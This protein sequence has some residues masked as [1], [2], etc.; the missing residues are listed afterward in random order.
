ME[1]CKLTFLEPWCT[2]SIVSTIIGDKI[3]ETLSSNGVTLKKTQSTHLPSIQ[4]LGVCCFLQLARTVAHD[5]LKGVWRESFIFPF[6]S[7]QNV[8]EAPRAKCLN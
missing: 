3:V 4:S 7:W 5:C 2:L 6:V 8:R 1:S